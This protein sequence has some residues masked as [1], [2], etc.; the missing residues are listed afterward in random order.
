VAAIIAPSAAAEFHDFEREFFVGMVRKLGFD[1]V[2][3]VAFGA[4]L[5]AKSY[6]ELLENKSIKDRQFI[7][8]SCPAVINLV[9]KYHP[10][11]IDS[12]APIVSP[13]VATSRVVRKKY[14]K[15]YKIVFIGP[16]TAKK[17]EGF[18]KDIEGEVDCVLTF[19]ELRQMFEE[20][21]ITPEG[22]KATEFDPPWGGTGSLF[23]V[24]GGLLQAGNIKEDLITEDVIAINDRVHF[25]EALKEFASGNLK[26]RL[27]EILACEGCIMGAGMTDKSSHFQR[28]HR[29]GKYTR[30]RLKKMSMERW[31]KDIEEFSK[32]DMSR[33]Y[34]AKDQRQNDPGDE[35]IQKILS[36]MGKYSKEDELNCGACGY[37]TCREHALAIYHNLAESEMC[38]PYT[39]GELEKA[40]NELEYSNDKLS[41]IQEALMHAERLASMGQ[42]AAG[43][44]HEINNP[45]GVILMY[46]HLMQENGELD[47]KSLE[48][49]TLIAS[50]ADRCK[51]IVAGLLKFQQT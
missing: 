4:D 32:L 15:H 1:K 41:T 46:A 34:S 13:M 5:V 35:V 7:A 50:Q 18:D 44:A 11:I 38:L 12:L 14:G 36:K 6:R 8:T 22:I 31:R 30:N 45:L 16:C 40:V 37:P 17:C 33:K 26:A 10:D 2:N 23:P 48:D 9:E 3:E 43:I 21:K 47:N 51:K 27:L 25:V 19:V 24:G 42:L 39:I 28:R 29:I 20:D 49:A